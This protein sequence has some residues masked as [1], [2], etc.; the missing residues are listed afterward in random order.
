MNRD[1]D[2][3]SIHEHFETLT[4]PRVE[5]TKRYPL[6]NLIFI[7]ICSV[8]C[9]NE[10]FTGMEVF[11]KAR[12]KWLEQS[13]DL[14]EG[15]PSHDTFGDVFAALDPEQF[16]QCLLDWITVC[17]E[18]QTGKSWRLMGRHCG[19]LTPTRRRNRP[20]TWSVPGPHRTTFPWGKP[21]WKKNPTRLRRFPNCWN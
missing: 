15:I 6:I 12:R 21:W 13:L 7:G 20:F 1:Q 18:S 2:V 14:S 9:G 19:G 3:P 4:D 10:T 8:I 16:Q 17:I 5:R 11:G